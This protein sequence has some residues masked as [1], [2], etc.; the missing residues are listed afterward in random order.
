MRHTTIKMSKN[1]KRK[2]K[3]GIK[4]TAREKLANN[5]PPKNSISG[6][7]SRNLSSQDNKGRRSEIQFQIHQYLF[8]CHLS[9]YTSL[10]CI[11]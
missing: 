3:T 10:I 6:F 9:R 7:L 4:H 8:L 11:A 5:T 2:T 1:Q